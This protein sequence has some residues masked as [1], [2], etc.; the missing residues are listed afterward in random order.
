MRSYLV[1]G[2]DVEHGMHGRRILW[3]TKGSKCLLVAGLVPGDS[4]QDK[5]DAPRRP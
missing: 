3:Q 4:A 1:Q 2:A 5:G